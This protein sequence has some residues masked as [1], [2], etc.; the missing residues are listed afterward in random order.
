MKPSR[1]KRQELARKKRITRERFKCRLAAL[2][3][4]EFCQLA[5]AR[6]DGFDKEVEAARL[7]QKVLMFGEMYGL[8][9]AEIL[10]LLA[11]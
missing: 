1:K 10:R 6:L 9:R 2:K 8:D 3:F 7:K 5:T 11:K 4:N